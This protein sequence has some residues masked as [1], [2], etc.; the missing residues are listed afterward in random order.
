[1]YILG[2]FLQSIAGLIDMLCTLLVWLV[3][4][5]ALLSWVSPDPYNPIVR[6]ISQLTEPLLS[7][8]RKK[9]PYWQG[10]DLAPIAAILALYFVQS[11]AVPTLLRMAQNLQ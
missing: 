5:R 10:I 4:I 9:L 2:Y 11:F 6:I 3:I 8:L 7:P 1:M